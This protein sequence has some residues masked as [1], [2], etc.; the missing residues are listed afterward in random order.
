MSFLSPNSWSAVILLQPNANAS[1]VQ[2]KA[3]PFNN[4]CLD[5]FI[6][7]L[8]WLWIDAYHFIFF[9]NKDY[10]IFQSHWLIILFLFHPTI[11]FYLLLCNWQNTL[12]GVTFV[13][14]VELTSTWPSNSSIDFG[15]LL[16]VDILRKMWSCLTGIVI[17]WKQDEDVYSKNMEKNKLFRNS[18]MD[19][20]AAHKKK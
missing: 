2:T 1:L 9:V 5:K 6:L 14:V 15:T 11:S 8:V 16:D 19:H 18:N 3:Y 12:V 20:G 7:S 10:C 13:A 17:N 4:H